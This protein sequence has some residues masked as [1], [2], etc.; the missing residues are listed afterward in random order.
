MLWFSFS[1]ALHLPF[2]FSISLLLSFFLSLLLSVCLASSLPLL[3][4]LSFFPFYSPSLYRLLFLFLSV[5]LL[6]ISLRIPLSFS[7]MFLFLSS[8]FHCN[9]VPLS[10]TKYISFSFPLSGSK[11]SDLQ[12]PWIKALC[13]RT[14]PELRCRPYSQPWLPT[15]AVKK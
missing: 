11:Y 9:S 8:F 7:I 12:W 14:W 13:Y 6:S 1:L 5:I 4:S 2:F 10:D 15:H 3:C